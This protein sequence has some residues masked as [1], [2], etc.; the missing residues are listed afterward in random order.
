M[1]VMTM[2]ELTIFLGVKFRATSYLGLMLFL[3]SLPYANNLAADE[4]EMQAMSLY[5]NNHLAEI[6]SGIPEGEEA[7]YGFQDRDEIGQAAQGIP[8]QEYDLETGEPTG[9]WRVPVTVGGENRALLRLKNSGEGW[10]FSGLG[11]AELARN[12]G[13]HEANMISKGSTPRSGRIVRDFTMRC[14]YVQ[15]DQQLGAELSGTV[16]PL[17]SASRFISTFESGE[18]PT[19]T[20]YAGYDVTKIKEIR[21]RA[22][23]MMGDP[24]AL[25]NSGWGNQ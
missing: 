5:V 8:Y 17:W 6:L 19:A 4:A 24:N 10:V 12:L 23:E 14:D 2:R 15:F 3:F 21:L 1:N 7:R 20:D 11:G 18:G 9:H 25:G 16:Y 13:D 22:Q